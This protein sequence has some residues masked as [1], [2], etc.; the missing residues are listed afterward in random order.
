MIWSCVHGMCS[1][2]I[3]ARTKGVHLKNPDTIVL[4]AHDE[5]IKFVEE[6]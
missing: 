1:L 2:K 6:K 4:D 3:R 5:F